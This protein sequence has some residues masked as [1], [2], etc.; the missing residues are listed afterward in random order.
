MAELGKRQ[1]ERFN[2]SIPTAVFLK[3]EK[4]SGREM[5]L[6]LKTKNIC[7]SGAFLITDA[8]LEIGTS[9]DVNLQLSFFS[10]N[11]ERERRSIVHVSGAIIRIESGG[12]AVKFDDKYQICPLPRKI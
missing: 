4:A 3:A 2:L 6:E 11:V 8:P 10:G 5:P 9:V 1:M 12:M 7:A